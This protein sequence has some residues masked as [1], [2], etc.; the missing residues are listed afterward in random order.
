VENQRNPLQR[1][2]RQPKIYLRLPSSGNFYPKGSIEYTETGE[3]PVFAMT[4]KDEMIIRTP[5]A[6][7]NGQSTVDVIQSCIPNIKNAWQ[8]PSIDIDA[9]LIAIR[10]ATYGEGLDITTVIPG[11]DESRSYVT[12]LRVMLDRLLAAVYDPV[13]EIDGNLKIYTRPL[14]YREFTQNAIKSLEEQ[15]ILSIVSDDSMDDAKKL[16]MFTNSFKKLTDLTINMVGQS[17][18]KIQVDGEEVTDQVMINEFIQN[19]DKEFYKR[20]MDHL[21]EQKKKFSIPPM[22]IITTEEERSKGAPDELDVPITMDQSN[23]FV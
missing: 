13:I 12:D 15:R 17:V 3:Y 11:L 10:I 8:I 14:N 22:K 23:F 9:I 7:L 19:A 16:S 2:Y 20:I 5:D 4:A 18:E 21:E 1:Y 6:L